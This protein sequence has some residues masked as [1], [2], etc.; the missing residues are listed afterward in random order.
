MTSPC[1]QLKLT[2]NETKHLL[3]SLRSAY[4]QGIRAPEAFVDFLDGESHLHLLQARETESKSRE[5]WRP[6]QW[7]AAYVR[8]AR[9]LRQ[10]SRFGRR[11]HTK[12]TENRS[13]G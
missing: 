13:S 4:S 2:K 7:R 12:I 8:I 11:L 1:A 3:A 9:K 6:L 10:A 5:P